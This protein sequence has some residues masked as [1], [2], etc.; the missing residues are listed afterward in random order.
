[1]KGLHADLATP[2]TFWCDLKIEKQIENREKLS[3]TEA[4]FELSATKFLHLDLTPQYLLF[5]N[6]LK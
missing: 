5:R 1:M 3:K 4:I 6:D 2:G